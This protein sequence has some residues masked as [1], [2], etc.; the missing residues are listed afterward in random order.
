VKHA[1]LVI[2]LLFAGPLNG[3]EPKPDLILL[4]DRSAGVVFPVA[5]LSSEVVKK[6]LA[7]GL[8]TTFL[9]TASGGSVKGAARIE[10]RYDL[11]DEVWIVR[12]IEFDRHSDQQRLADRAALEKWW[13]KPVRMFAAGSG[14]P[15]VNIEMA[16]LPFS[17]DEEEDTRRWIAKSG[18][19][20]GTGAGGGFVDVLIG[21][22]IS[23]RPL[24]TY[25]WRVELSPR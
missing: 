2:V 7:S 15:T 8:T 14:H 4:P 6:Q 11:W 24:I 25:R 9:A 23:A 21:T 1:L 12:R 17:A 20:G 18:G 10:I 5:I 22:T 19:V 13:A 16:V 3:A